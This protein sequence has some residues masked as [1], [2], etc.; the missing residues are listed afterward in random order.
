M[1]DVP[2]LQALLA[3]GADADGL[4][5]QGLTPLMFAAQAGSVEMVK[6]LLA[7]GADVNAKM[8]VDGEETDQ[9]AL[10]LAQNAGFEEVT[11]LL[12]SSGAK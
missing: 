7:A 12:K 5:P 8:V 9:T 2:R 11:Q 3:D 4:S 6:I 10:Q 1:N